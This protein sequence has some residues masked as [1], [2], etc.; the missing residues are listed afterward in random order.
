MRPA[1]LSAI[2]SNSVRT[3]NLLPADERLDSDPLPPVIT[4][5]RGLAPGEVLRI[6]H[7][8]EP[9]PFY[10]LWRRMGGFTWWA[11]QR[12]PDEWWIWVRRLP[13]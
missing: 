7:K 10:D 3:V 4:A 8:W 1:W 12:G 13:T 5:M 11:E 6:R 2:A 9:Q